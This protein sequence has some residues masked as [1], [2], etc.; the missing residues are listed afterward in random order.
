LQ[1][2]L[3]KQNTLRIFMHIRNMNNYININKK[4]N[5]MNNTDTLVKY[6]FGTMAATLLVMNIAAFGIIIVNGIIS[7]I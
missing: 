7:L 1:R 5:N 2:Y 3:E 6:T 4:I